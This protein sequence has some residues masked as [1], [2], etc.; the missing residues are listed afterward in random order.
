MTL[1][2]K[3]IVNELCNYL[4]YDLDDCMCKEL[5]EA[6]ETSPELQAYINSIKTTVKICQQ[7][8]TEEALPEDVKREL[9]EKI[10]SRRLSPPGT[11]D[12]SATD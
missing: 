3:K 8:Y 2:S 10:K 6:V 1:K 5:H 4:G 12:P 9:L 11:S 7:V